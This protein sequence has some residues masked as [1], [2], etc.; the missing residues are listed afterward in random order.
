MLLTKLFQIFLYA[1]MWDRTLDDLRTIF[2]VLKIAV[3]VG[4]AFLLYR[5]LRKYYQKTD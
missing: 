1:G 2:W 3:A 5:T 4:L